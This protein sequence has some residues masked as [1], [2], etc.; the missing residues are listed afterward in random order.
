MNA[1]VERVLRLLVNGFPWAVW[2]CGIL[3]LLYAAACYNPFLF[4]AV[5]VLGKMT[6][7]VHLLLKLYSP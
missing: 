3:Y 7:A 6:Y 1:F 4:V 5:V 2:I